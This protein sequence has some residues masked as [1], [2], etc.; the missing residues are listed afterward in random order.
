MCLARGRPFIVPNTRLIKDCDGWHRS[1]HAHPHDGHVVSMAVLRRDLDALFSNVRALCDG[2][3]AVSSD[4]SM[5][6]QTYV[7]YH[8]RLTNHILL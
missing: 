6:A 8:S 1:N 2:S 7:L 3:Q 4:G 5:V